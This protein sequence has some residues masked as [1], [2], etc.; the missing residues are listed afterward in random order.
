LVT[1]ITYLIAGVLALGYACVP[2]APQWRR[3]TAAGLAVILTVTSG[4]LLATGVDGPIGFHALAGLSVLA[5][6]AVLALPRRP[7]KRPA[8]AIPHQARHVAPGRA[9]GPVIHDPWAALYASL[10]A[11]VVR[12][13]KTA[14]T[15]K[16]PYVPRRR[17]PAIPASIKRVSRCT[18]Q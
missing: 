3:V 10:A 6:A 5:F 18:R 11:Q 2:T 4:E 17:S 1:L 8:P 13:A 16:A 14:A 9:A 12:P 15:A 7:V